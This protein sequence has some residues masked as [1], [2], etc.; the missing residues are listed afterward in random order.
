MELLISD[1]VLM[2]NCQNVMNFFLME[3]LVTN[4]FR[5]KSCLK[6]ARNFFWGRASSHLSLLATILKVPWNYVTSWI[7]IYLG[8]FTTLA[9]SRFW[10]KTLII[11]MWHIRFVHKHSNFNLVMSNFDSFYVD[12]LILCGITTLY[13]QLEILEKWHKSSMENN[14]D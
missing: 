4:V 2:K 12:H 3:Y 7:K 10:K 14:L 9:P 5:K 11:L 8:M 1:F 13:K 6:S